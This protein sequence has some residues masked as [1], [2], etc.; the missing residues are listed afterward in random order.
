MDDVDVALEG[1]T[2]PILVDSITQESEHTI[3][4]L[5]RCYCKVSVLENFNN[6]VSVIIFLLKK[7]PQQ[8]L[9][10]FGAREYCK[11]ALGVI[12]V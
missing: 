5:R 6:L 8:L 12:V 7:K 4:F 9:D 10:E 11:Q 2:R 1:K 3:C